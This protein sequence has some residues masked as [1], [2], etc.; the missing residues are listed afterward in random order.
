MANFL[1]YG[2][3]GTGKSTLAMRVAQCSGRHLM[4][5][6]PWDFHLNKNGFMKQLVSPIIDGHIVSAKR[7]IFIFEEFDTAVKNLHEKQL[8]KIFEDKEIDSFKL[9]DDVKSSESKSSRSKST[10]SQCN[11]LELDDL[12]EILQGACPIPGSVIFAT[13][14]DYEYIRKTLPA[15]VR[16]GRLTPIYIDYLNWESFEELVWYFFKCKPSIKKIQFKCSTAAIINLAMA[17]YTQKDGIKLFE[18]AIIDMTVC[19]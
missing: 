10:N 1:L 18:Q 14:N 16:P 8:T 15:L 12:K 3:P 9:D 7:V 17:F 11:E 19:E 2:P 6:N 5:L 13:T 4:S